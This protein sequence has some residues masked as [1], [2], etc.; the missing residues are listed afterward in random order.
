MPEYKLY[1]F[2]LA[3]VLGLYFVIT[4]I[5]GLYRATYYRKLIAD[6]KGLDFNGVYAALLGLLI[7]LFLVLSQD[8][9]S[10][11]NLA[12]L[13][14]ISW[15]VLLKAIL[16]LVI[17]EQMLIYLKRVVASPAYYIFNVIFLLVGCLII[18]KA[19][20]LFVLRTGILS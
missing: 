13:S 9:W 1:S 7:G 5:I 15:S 6:F 19:F 2:L 4:A 14:L 16:W 3:Q 17:P 10:N 8:N 12:F 11:I 20:Y 18:N